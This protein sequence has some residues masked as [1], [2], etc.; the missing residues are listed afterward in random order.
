MRAKLKRNGWQRRK[1]GLSF[2]KA[3][4]AARATHLLHIPLLPVWI[5]KLHPDLGITLGPELLEP[6]HPVL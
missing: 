4:T 3:A 1:Q 5:S 6:F 2:Q